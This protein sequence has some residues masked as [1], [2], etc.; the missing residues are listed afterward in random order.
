[1]DKSLGPSA[2]HIIT[3]TLRHIFIAAHDSVQGAERSK[4]YDINCSYS[5][6]QERIKPGE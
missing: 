2:G 3:E 6:W 4:T 1:M 5:L